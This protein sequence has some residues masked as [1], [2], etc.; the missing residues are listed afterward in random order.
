MKQTVIML[1]TLGVLALGTAPGGNASA[2]LDSPAATVRASIPTASLGWAASKWSPT[3]GL[4]VA[5]AALPR[6][7]LTSWRIGSQIGGLFGGIAGAVVGGAL[8][9]F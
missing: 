7:V 8:G 2:D 1:A 4:L 6:T 9:G 5:G 3:M